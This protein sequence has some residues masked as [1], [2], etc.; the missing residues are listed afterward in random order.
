M[1]HVGL[2]YLLE[3]VPWVERDVWY[4]KCL[5]DAATVQIRR[6]AECVCDFENA[7]AAAALTPT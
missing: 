4:W 3:H 6:V 1:V 2:G 7:A 5:A